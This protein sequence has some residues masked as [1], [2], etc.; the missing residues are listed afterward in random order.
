MPL[1]SF[2]TMTPAPVIS[3]LP[4]PSEIHRVES[5]SSVAR[6]QKNSFLIPFKAGMLLKTRERLT[7][8]PNYERLFRRKCRGFAIFETNLCGFCKVRGESGGLLGH[9]VSMGRRQAHLLGGWRQRVGLFG[10][11]PTA[12]QKTT[13]HLAQRRVKRSAH[14]RLPYVSTLT[15]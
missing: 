15:N 5:R 6:C 1:P 4:Q 8:G 7:K 14:P 13:V 3:P 9:Q 11:D 10:K 12:R 2:S